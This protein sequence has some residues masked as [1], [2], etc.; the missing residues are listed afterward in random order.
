M[1]WKTDVS[2]KVTKKSLE[3]KRVIVMKKTKLSFL[4]MKHYN[5]NNMVPE[6]TASELQRMDKKARQHNK[7][8]NFNNKI[9]DSIEKKFFSSTSHEPNGSEIIR[10]LPVSKSL[11]ANKCSLSHEAEASEIS[12]HLFST[13]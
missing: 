4:K 12:S 9:V 10:D 5:E 1:L 8:A 13:W 2:P 7:I 6:L 3:D 11:I